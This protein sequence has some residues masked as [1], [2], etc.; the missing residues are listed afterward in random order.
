MSEILSHDYSVFFFF[1]VVSLD[2]CDGVE[3]QPNQVCQL[4]DGRR[5]VCRCGGSCTSEFSPVCG[6]DGRTYSNE[7]F[8]R[9][10][11]CKS[12]RDIRTLSRGECTTGEQE[13]EDEVD[14]KEEEE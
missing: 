2:P 8:L 12:G 4:D 11:A 10:E 1:V 5:P 6:S 13:E 7:C 9:T 3:C 14:E